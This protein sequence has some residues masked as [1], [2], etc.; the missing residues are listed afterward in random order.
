M[1]GLAVR[2]WAIPRPTHD[3]D[4]AVALEGEA[5]LDLLRVLDQEGFSVDQ[6]FI[7]GFADT[8]SGMRKVNIGCFES[9]TMWRIDIFLASTPF[10][11][12]AFDRRVATTI[13]GM[14]LNVVTAED[15]TVVRVARRSQ[16]GSDGCR[17]HAAGV[18]SARPFLPAEVGSAPGR[19]RNGTIV[20]LPNDRI[21]RQ[22]PA[23][24]A[25]EVFYPRSRRTSCCAATP[26]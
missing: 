4:F 16:Q 7:T 5:L 18:R 19:L 17:G 11:R 8:L 26:P 3:V 23:S 21:R 15:P 25:S 24:C 10:A 12:S 13:E 14:S 9:G 2:H 1:G 22:T 6:Q 20:G